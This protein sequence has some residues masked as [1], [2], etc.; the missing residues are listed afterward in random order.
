MTPPS[1]YIHII[2]KVWFHLLFNSFC[3]CTCSKVLLCALPDGKYYV[4]IHTE[5]RAKRQLRSNSFGK[6]LKRHSNGQMQFAHTSS[7]INGV[8]FLWV[9]QEQSSVAGLPQ[10]CGTG[11]GIFLLR[12]RSLPGAVPPSVCSDPGSQG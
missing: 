12:F 3:L 11:R 4:C 1:L 9:T 6:K 5:L 7:L 2:S 8:K 10:P